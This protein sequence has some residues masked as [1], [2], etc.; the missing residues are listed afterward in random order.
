[1]NLE[2]SFINHCR[3]GDMISMKQIYLDNAISINIIEDSFLLAYDLGYLDIVLWLYSLKILD[4]N[5]I[6]DKLIEL[7]E[8]YNKERGTLND[9]W[10]ATFVVAI[11]FRLGKSFFKD[12]VWDNSEKC[13]CNHYEKCFCGLGGI[14]Y[15]NYKGAVIRMLSVV[16]T[17]NTQRNP[18]KMIGDI[19][20]YNVEKNNNIL[21]SIVLEKNIN[22]DSIKRYKQI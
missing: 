1:M 6:K 11:G 5:M 10:M 14:N 15:K 19:D 16:S 4:F 17:I 3:N 12:S 7:Y 22:N 8:K 9:M 20:F 18:R 2:E 13:I 21:R